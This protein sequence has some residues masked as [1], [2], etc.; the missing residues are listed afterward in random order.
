MCVLIV[1]DDRTLGMV[2]KRNLDKLGLRSYLAETGEA[3]IEQFKAKTSAFGL[4]LLD[5]GLPQKDG[6]TVAHEMRALGG[7]CPIVAITA[8]HSSKEECLSV[9]ID[10]YFTKPVLINELASIIDKWNIRNCQHEP[11]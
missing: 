6:L 2:Y 7:E 4:V 10:D 3:A 9:G 8:G 1:E 11:S 5:I